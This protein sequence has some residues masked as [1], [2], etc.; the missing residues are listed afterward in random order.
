MD[1]DAIAKI[2]GQ[3]VERERKASTKKTTETRK[4]RKRRIE[5]VNRA[6]MSVCAVFIPLYAN[7]CIMCITRI[8]LPQ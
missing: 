1:S 5:A 3:Y 8:Y 4:E 2:K 6:A 7:I